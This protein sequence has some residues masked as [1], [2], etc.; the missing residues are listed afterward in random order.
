MIAATTL[1][2]ELA[3][4]ER[5]FDD[6]LEAAMPNP[7]ALRFTDLDLGFQGKRDL[8]FG[9]ALLEEGE[10][11]AALI[12]GLAQDALA[13]NPTF[14]IAHLLREAWYYLRTSIDPQWQFDDPPGSFGPALA[15]IGTLVGRRVAALTPP[16]T[17]PSDAPD[18][19]ERRALLERLR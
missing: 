5:I 7:V 15:Y 18:A 4:L 1:A 9:L 8:V 6:A 3:A 2:G 13:R 16:A 12:A 19:A 10:N 17:L 14:E 11:E